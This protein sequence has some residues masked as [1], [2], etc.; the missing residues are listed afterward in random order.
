MNAI[1]TAILIAALVQFAQEQCHDAY[2]Q[3]IRDCLD[4]LRMSEQQEREQQIASR[5]L[6]PG[7][8]N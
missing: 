6:L 4:E 5:I 3:G 7:R 2:A 1:A 8:P